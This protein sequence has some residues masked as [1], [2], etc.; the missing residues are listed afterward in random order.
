[1]NIAMLSVLACRVIL[2]PL[3]PDIAGLLAQHNQEA[4]DNLVAYI[5]AYVSSTAECMPSNNALPLSGFTY[6]PPIASAFADVDMAMQQSVHGTVSS[7]DA[8]PCVGLSGL[9]EQGSGTRST[10][11][12]NTSPL[13]LYHCQVRA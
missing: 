2:E 10:T 12:S 4:V 6:P 1:M 11:R 8:A 9:G 5:T 3:N 7:A 13:H